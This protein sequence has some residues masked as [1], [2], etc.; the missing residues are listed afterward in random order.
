MT[1]SKNIYPK[2]KKWSEEELAKLKQLSKN[3]VAGDIA[4]EF[5][6]S[7]AQVKWKLKSLGLTTRAPWARPF[8][9]RL[10]IYKHLEKYGYKKTCEVFKI[11]YKQAS[12]IKSRYLKS[13][14][15]QHLKADPEALEK[16]RR[17]AVGFAR[18]RGCSFEDAEDFGIHAVVKK[19]ELGRIGVDVYF[20]FINWIEEKHSIR[21]K[22]DVNYDENLGFC[23]REETNENKDREDFLRLIK[24][25]DQ[26]YKTI[27]ILKFIFNFN[28]KDIGVVLQI[29]ESRICQLY[30]ALLQDLKVSFKFNKQR[31]IA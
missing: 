17:Y 26:P 12:K 28:Y 27:L 21:K 10:K 18:K 23:N 9:L 1:K 29:S 16:L 30:T 11:S 6:L 31:M 4:K 22:K 7:L 20:L 24:T 15:E 3:H 2:R 13:I 19:I 8:E 5:N 14:K 25:L